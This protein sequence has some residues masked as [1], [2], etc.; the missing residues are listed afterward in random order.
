MSFLN[1]LKSI[2]LPPAKNLLNVALQTA[3]QTIP[4]NKNKQEYEDPGAPS[5]HGSAGS[6]GSQMSHRPQNVRFAESNG[7]GWFFNS[8]LEIIFTEIFF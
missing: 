4:G 7:D 5:E 1:T 3:R 8:L 2:P 6:G